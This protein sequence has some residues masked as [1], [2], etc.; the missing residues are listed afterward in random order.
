[1][2]R[3]KEAYFRDHPN[4]MDMET[5]SGCREFGGEDLRKYILI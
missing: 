4:W 5:V 3:T 1:M 2:K